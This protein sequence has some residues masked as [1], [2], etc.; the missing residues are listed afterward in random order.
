MRQG[1]INNMAQHSEDM[2]EE[3]TS[4]KSKVDFI[5]MAG[6]EP[7]LAEFVTEFIEKPDNFFAM[8]FERRREIENQMDAILSSFGIMTRH[9]PQQ[10]HCGRGD[11]DLCRSRS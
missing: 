6:I 11:S 2:N 10:F 1:D 5:R 7:E 3:R 4:A 9:S 8:P